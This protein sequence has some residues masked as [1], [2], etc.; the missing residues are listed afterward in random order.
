MKLIKLLENI[1]YKLIKGNLEFEIE[2]ITY[3]SRTANKTNCFVALVGIDRDGHDYIE[4][5]IKQGCKCIIVSKSIDINYDINI[6]KVNNTRKI[7]P[8]ISA[9][10]FDNPGDKLIKIGITGTKGKTSVSYILK[11]L[12]EFSGKKVGVIGT[13]GTIIGNKKIE[14]KNTTPE[15]YLVQKYMRYMVDQNVKYLIM[16]VSSQAL[17]VGRVSNII[18]DYAIFTNLSLDH[19]GK[20]EHE[21]YEDY[22]YSKSLL[23]KQSKIGIINKDEKEY[24]KII[25]NATSKIITYGKSNADYIIS[26]INKIIKKDLLGMNFKINNEEF[27]IGMLGEF[28]VYNATS[29]IAIAKILNISNDIIN[30]ALKNIS[31]EGRME[32]INVDNKYKVIIDYAHNNLSIETIIKTARDFGNY[33]VTIIGCGGG[34]AKE[35]RIGIGETVGKL[36]DFTIITSD[37]PRYDDLNEINNDIKLGV[38]KS[39][40]KYIIINDREEAIK[41]A[42]NKILNKDIILILGKGHEKFQEINGKIYD[43]DERKIVE[44]CIRGKSENIR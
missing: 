14:H 20:K 6:I 27:Y 44:K 39:N 35:L 16:E 11:Q 32:V 9:N 23:F 18:F 17:K 25:K 3:D 36:S 43:F 33:I 19:V 31:I 29:V 30:K 2:D 26:D 7:L 24:N 22:V 8:I 28:S 41:Y 13:N 38:E 34:R 12:L 15:S 42:I 21:S 5:V 1:D 37:N 10:L 4:S 40:G